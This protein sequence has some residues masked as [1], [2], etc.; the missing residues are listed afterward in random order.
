[1]RVAVQTPG[2][3]PQTSSLRNA[4]A[5][6]EAPG[7]L[8]DLISGLSGGSPLVRVPVSTAQ[9]PALRGKCAK[10]EEQEANEELPHGVQPRLAVG[11]V[12]DPLE[13]EADH[14]ADRVMRMAGPVRT[15]DAGVTLQ[16]KCAACEERQRN[17]AA[18]APAIVHGVLRSSGER[19]DAST[20]AFFE[21]RFGR[22]FSQVRVH[23][24]DRAAKSAKSVG[25]LA[26]AAGP[27]IVFAHGQYAPSGESGRRL[28]AHELAHTVQQGHSRVQR[29]PDAIPQGETGHIDRPEDL[30]NKN[31]QPLSGDESH[32]LLQRDPA[33]AGATPGA[34]PRTCGPDITSSLTTMLGTVGPWFRGLST[35][36]K[37]RS[38]IALGPGAPAVGVNPIMAWDT[39]EL[40][41]PNT[42]W[43]DGYVARQSC[44]SPRDAGC[45][46][47]DTRN[48]CET[49]DG[50]G[51]SVVVGGKCLLAGTANYALFGTMCRLCHDATSQWG[52]WDMRA[53]IGAY[54]TIAGDDS[55]PPKEV[56]SAAFDGAFPTLPPAAENRGSCDGR[57]GATHSGSFDF[58]WEPYKSR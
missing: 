18:G 5:S 3:V 45:D 37:H 9:G 44:G 28:L 38:C 58:I 20:R 7:C 52:R 29:Q 57:C 12:D 25:A 43:L 1:M 17:S 35:F 21:P 49:A 36:R 8:P 33:P 54:K 4:A 47:D 46:T 22:D 10:C 53:I 55:T 50:C 23:A 15:A 40:F 19:L 14:I 26:Y 2:L 34:R 13:H 16:S 27:H 31:S 41:L 30:K 56:A 32:G 42:G 51:N 48:K 6:N 39:R 24:D 11:S